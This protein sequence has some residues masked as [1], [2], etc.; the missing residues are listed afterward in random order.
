[1]DGNLTNEITP[2]EIIFTGATAPFEMSNQTDLLLY[3][4]L[5]FIVIFAAADFSHSALK[6]L[7]AS[8]FSRVSYY[9][10][11][12]VLIAMASAALVFFYILIPTLYAT[13]LNGFGGNFGAEYLDEV[14]KV[15]LPQ[16][17][18]VFSFGCLGLFITFTFKKTAILNTL[19]IAWS[20]APTLI[21]LIISENI[22]LKYRE[23]L[24][25]DMI[26]VIKSF[27]FTDG[28]MPPS[29]SRALVLGTVYILLSTIG[30]ILLFR[31][32]EV[33]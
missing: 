3:F 16:L 13:A 17:Y 26:F 21:I 29:L 18:L 25:Y 2:L 11:K 24:N 19:Y 22:D 33:K 5:P 14:F 10:A 8:G 30:G 15:Y 23:L 12:I 20:L 27:A 9:F 31:K 4:L 1:M 7:L 28:A 6:N 32:C